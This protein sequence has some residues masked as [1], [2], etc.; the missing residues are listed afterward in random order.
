MGRLGP[1][2]LLVILGILLIIMG[3]K[4]LPELGRSLAG[5]IREFR[6]GRAEPSEKEGAAGEGK[7]TKQ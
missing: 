3:P 4:K 6:A 2:E 7:E 1:T 5:A